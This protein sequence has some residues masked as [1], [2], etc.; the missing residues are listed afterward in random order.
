MSWFTKILAP[1]PPPPPSKFIWFEIAYNFLKGMDIWT[2]CLFCFIAIAI[3]C[4]LAVCM[5][6]WEFIE[7]RFHTFCRFLVYLLAIFGFINLPGVGS[8]IKSLLYFFA[9]Y[10][11]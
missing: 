8:V 9:E 4:A 1:A 5:R 11:S 2:L 10:G 6:T 7:K 3:C